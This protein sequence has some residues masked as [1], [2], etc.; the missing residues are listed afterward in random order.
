MKSMIRILLLVSLLSLPCFGADKEPPLAPAYEGHVFDGRNAEEKGLLGKALE[1]YKKAQE[2]NPKRPDAY[3]Y[4]AR[5]LITQRKHE[6]AVAALTKLIEL[7]PASPTAFQMRGTEYFKLGEIEKS[8]QDFDKYISFKPEDEPH[9]WQ[10][11]ISY[12]YAGKFSEGRRQF[13]RHQTVNSN[14]VE[15]A[16]WHFL[17]IARAENFEK[18]SEALIPITGD[19][20][21]PMTQI[22][23]L[24]AGKGTEADI[25]K[26]IEAGNPSPTILEQRKF[27]AHLYLGLYF[28]AKGDATRAYEHIKKAATEFPSDHYMG[29]VAKVHFKRL[30]ANPPKPSL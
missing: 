30:L 22:F 10:R 12:Y 26:A 15:N 8:I 17:C 1:S 21:V 27:Y 28:E 2:L 19:Q 9:H 24:F 25:W 18:A 11:G 3:F 13:E 29:D 5:V 14:D 20:R 23:N 16:V 6:E 4:T 7:Q